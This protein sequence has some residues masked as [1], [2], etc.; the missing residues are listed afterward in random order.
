MVLTMFLFEDSQAGAIYPQEA[1]VNQRKINAER[2]KKEKESKKQ[3]EK[4]V[5]QHYDHQSKETKAMMKRAKRETKKNT[6]IK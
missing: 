1:K 6:P 2:A 3:Y 5:K 4:A